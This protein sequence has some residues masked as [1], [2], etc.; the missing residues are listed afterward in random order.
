[1]ISEAEESE[2][3]T[4]DSSTAIYWY[5]SAKTLC[6]GT[7][8]NLSAITQDWHNAVSVVHQLS[9]LLRLYGVWLTE[10]ADLWIMFKFLPEFHYCAY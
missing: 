2:P 4:F 9:Q 6:L 1:M 8:R 3:N 5:K 10:T 7:A